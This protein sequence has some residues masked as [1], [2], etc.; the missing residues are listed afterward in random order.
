MYASYNVVHS[1][2][3]HT[4]TKTKIGSSPCH[5]I[6]TLSINAAP[7]AMK[8]IT[9][10]R[11]AI[12]AFTATAH[13]RDGAAIRRPEPSAR[14]GLP[15]DFAAVLASG[16]RTVCGVSLIRA[17][18]QAM[19]SLSW[20]KIRRSADVTMYSFV[21]PGNS[22]TDSALV[23]EFTID[24][25]RQRVFVWRGGGAGINGTCGPLPNGIASG[26]LVPSATL[27]R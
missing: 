19:K 14:R 24:A 9:S 22:A 8:A 15:F 17:C 20:R 1:V 18:C 3:R 26:A 16:R 5:V 25:Q 12:H 2:G 21:L 6:A 10:V 4:R 7:P 13:V 11:S 23:V 27:S